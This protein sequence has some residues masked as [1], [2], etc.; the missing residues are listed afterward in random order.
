MTKTIDYK[1]SGVDVEAGDRLVEWIKR[2]KS[3]G[4]HKNVICGVGGFSA[5]FKL[6]L[7]KYKKPILV[8]CTDGVGTKVKLA[9]EL[10]RVEPTGI[11]LVAMCVNDLITCG[12]DP[13]FFLDYYASGKLKLENAQALLSGVLKGLEQSDCTLVGG[14]T[15]EMPGV[16]AGEDYDC[17]GFCVGVVDEDKLID[18]KSL[19]V[20]DVAIGISASGFH[21]NG[22]S[23]L[24]KLFEN[25]AKANAEMLMAPTR[26]YVPL[27]K[28]LKSLIT[29]KAMAH[30]T[31]GGITGNAPRVLLEN[32]ALKLQRWPWPDS[33]LEVQR[34][35]GLSAEQMLET[36]NCGI[37]FIIYVDQKDASLVIS[38]SVKFGWN[39]LPIGHI[40]KHVGE[41]AVIL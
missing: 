3:T 34:R 26:I 39:A 41:A 29:I 20:G 7:Q 5:L 15:A 33:Y 19:S 36:F 23:L 17:A 16:Y 40:V 8:S 32:T 11:D 28:N 10:N 37:G 13:L 24:R 31:G 4:S 18:G 1:T 14:E 22:F 2:Q 27:V 30:I 9:V 12:A 38:E 25:D 21:S 6:D 35:S